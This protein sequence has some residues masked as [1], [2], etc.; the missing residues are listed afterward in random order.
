MVVKGE[1]HTK[2]HEDAIENDKNTEEVEY[3]LEIVSQLILKMG[4][5]ERSLF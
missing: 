3:N 4:I 1:R 2:Q 5:A